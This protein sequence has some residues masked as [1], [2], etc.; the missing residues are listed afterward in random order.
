MR[1][2]KKIFIIG[3]NGFIGNE[4]AENILRTSDNEISGIDV[5]SFNIDRLCAYKRFHF[6]QADI[7]VKQRWVEK[8]VSA[9]DIIIPLAALVT[10][11]EYVRRP[12]SVFEID[13]EENLKIVRYCAKY[14]KRLVF[15]STSEVY[16]MCK[17]DEFDEDN[18]EFVLGPTR[19]QRWIYSCSKQ[20]L[21]RVIWAYGKQGK[22]NFTLFRPFNWIGPRLD[23]LES[24]R[25]KS[26]RV[27]TQL[28]LSLVEGK[29]ILLV[30]GGRQ[31]R[32]FTDISDGI[33]CLRGIIE[34]KNNVCAGKIFNIGNPDNEFTIKELAQMLVKK[35][36]SHPLRDMFPKFA[37][38]KYV[39]GG[40]FYGEGYQDVL[41]RKPCINNARRFLGWQPSVKLAVSLENTLNYFLEQ[42]AEAC[43][44]K[45][46]K[47]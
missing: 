1:K 17:D 25:K 31:K 3:V 30:D 22:L 19:M 42:A 7:R 36:K 18:S 38:L 23:G 39:V 46:R 44:Q 41:H 28:I 21:D 20:L 5:N 4:L 8:E 16:G 13:F 32:C 14:K 27:V 45:Q 47:K 2:R 6:K 11:I 34:N 33:A 26:S 43:P 24:A 9:S 12:L 40:T 35:F 29:P 10:P 37:G 15:P